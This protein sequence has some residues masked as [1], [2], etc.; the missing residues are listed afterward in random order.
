MSYNKVNRITL[1]EKKNIIKINSAESNIF[2]ITYDTFEYA[3]GDYT[4]EEKLLLLMVDL[5]QGNI[6]IS[7]INSSTDKFEYAMIKISH[8]LK[9]NN[10]DS[11]EDL[12]CKISE[13]HKRIVKEKLNIDL[14][15][16]YKDYRDFVKEHREEDRKIYIEVYREIYGECFKIFLNTIKIKNNKKYKIQFPSDYDYFLLKMGK[17]VNGYYSNYK[18][19]INKDRAEQ[20][21]FFKANIIKQIF[22]DNK[23]NSSIVEV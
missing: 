20:M 4:F 19:T 8:F 21:S 5:E 22:D 10:I 15:K 3:K 9:D 14:D 23:I 13:V 11:Y 12:Y 16:D 6:H 2:P 17:F 1:N 7:S 18:T